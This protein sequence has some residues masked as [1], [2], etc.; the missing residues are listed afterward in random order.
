M[1]KILGLDLGTNSIG[2]ALVQQ[3]FNDKEGEIL[4]VGSRIIPMDQG[5]L[6]KFDAGQSISK[7]SERTSY[8]GTRRL[9][10]RSN[11][12]RE[13]LHRVLNVL[14]FLPKHYSD[15]IDFKDKKGQFRDD[16]EPKIPYVKDRQGK[17]EFL[18]KASFNEMVSEFKETHPE[19]LENGKKIPYDWTI[20]YLRK[21]ALSQKIEKEELSWLILNFNQKRGYY[22]LSEE[23]EDIE[24][25]K[26]KEFVTLKV[27]EIVDTGDEVNGNKLYNVYFENGWKYDKSIVKTENWID[28]TK[29]FIITESKLKNGELKRTFRS[30]DSDDDWIAIEKKTEQEI[31]ASKKHVGEYIYETILSNPKQKIRGKLVKTIERK[32]YKKEFEK[33]LETQI[34]LHPEL[35]SDEL[36]YK[37][38]RELYPNN[39]AHRKSI[40][41][42]GFLYLFKDDIIFYQRPLKVKTHLISNCSFEYRIRRDN[43][44]K[45][46]LKC[47]TKSNP[48]F[49]EFRLWQ[50]INNLKAY[51]KEK[52]INGKKRFDVDVTNELLGSV[53]DRVDLFEW[54]NDREKLSQDQLLSHLKLNKETHRWNYVEDKEYPCNE[55]RAKFIKLLKKTKNLDKVELT[56]KTTQKLWHLLY[57]VTDPEERK[58]A[59]AK[60]ADSHNL[61]EAFK[62]VFSKFPPFKR[63]YGSYSE[64]AI[65][66]LLPLLRMGEY[67]SWNNIHEQTK[68]RIEKLLT[69]EFDEKIRDRVREKSIDLQKENDFQGLPLW[70][71]SYVVY[72][73]HSEVNDNNKWKTSQDIADYLNPKLKNSF[74]QH[75]LR[76]P[77]VEQVLTET[78]RVVKDIWDEY[79]NG[80]EDYFD[81]IHIELGRSMKNDK[82]TRERLSNKVTENENT[83]ERIKALL[84][85]LKNEVQNVK[86]FSPSQQE[87]LK[88]YEEGV[89][90]NET[91]KDELENA[92]KIR[93]KSSPSKKDIQ[94]YKLWLEQGYISPYTGSPIKLSDLFTHKYQ[95]EHI[96]P[97]SRYFDDSLTNKII[98]ESEVNEL[99]DNL[100]AYEFISK[101]GGTIVSIGSNK[102]VKVFDKDNYEQHVDSYF[103]KN[104]IKKERLLAD[105]IP[106]S[107][108]ERQMNDSR[109]ISKTVKNLLSKIVREEEEQET[110]SKNIVALPGSITSK[111]K[112]HWGLNDIWNTLI[113]PRFKRMNELTKSEDYG[114]INPNTNKFLP[115]VPN[116]IN[117]GFS[118]KRIDHR[119]HA[120]DALVI[121]CATKDHVNYLTSLNTERENFKLIEKLR[122]TKTIQKEK[123]MANGD[124]KLIKRRVAKNYLKP[125]DTFTEESLDALQSIIISFKQ[126]LRVINKATNKYEKW[127]L[128]NGEKKKKLVEQKGTNWSVRKPMHKEF[129]YGKVNLPFVKVPKDKSTTAIREEINTSFKSKK[130][131]SITDRGIQKILINHLEKFDDPKVQIDTSTI[132]SKIQKRVQMVKDKVITEHPEIKVNRINQYIKQESL[133]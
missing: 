91:R 126:N 10:Q 98:C 31:Q 118:K 75:S 56:S 114:N 105:E 18:F 4:G 52:V 22:Q 62:Q 122:D 106:E 130:I 47:I 1:K 101:Y 88:L 94:R 51:E 64:K 90:Q 38:I 26:K 80:E 112:H 7:T 66:K 95:I 19:L 87:I 5:L 115:K 104:K 27:K 50:F 97:Q 20:Y 14:N 124:K 15:K 12:R 33:I 65:K 58:K 86:P 49:Q 55:T 34:Q 29:E 32:F 111:L 44:E 25:G 78:L 133:R 24:E 131:G 35:Q 103:S 82:K 120:L 93:K 127:T 42:R 36:Y 72:D 2:W 17:H 37:C 109:Y 16:S 83:N 117:K 79:G 6:G 67:F 40:K 85:E 28:Q 123:V 116:E 71:A 110:T 54:L 81:E 11:L 48:L 23:V 99:K 125:W 61:N 73:R 113:T 102:E 39:D 57:S 21:K 107:F 84:E 45:V 3:D 129:I 68:A 132:T 60:F 74:K 77:I 13:R 53:K 59:I 70:L 100:T 119:H 69:G 89:Y 108:I 9:Y 96:I 41:N 30:V 63:D 43:K 8:R 92:Q 46:Y 128:E 121:A 76:N